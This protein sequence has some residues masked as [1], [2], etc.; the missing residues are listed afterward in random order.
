MK[1]YEERTRIRSTA[2][3]GFFARLRRI[4]DGYTEAGISLGHW[5]KEYIRL[6]MEAPPQP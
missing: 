5:E 2:E 4:H 3:E 1:C 6:M